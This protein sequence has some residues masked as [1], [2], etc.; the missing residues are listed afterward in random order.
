MLNPK[1]K[2]CLTFEYKILNRPSGTG[3][4]LEELL[5]SG[6]LNWLKNYQVSSMHVVGCENLMENPGDP[7]FLGYFK[8]KKLEVLGKCTDTIF[9]TE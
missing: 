4:C 5:G 1:G 7:T 9:P 2:L 3:K 8:D 6:L